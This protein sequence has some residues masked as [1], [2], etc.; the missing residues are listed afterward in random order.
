MLHLKPQDKWAKYRENGVDFFQSLTAWETL[1]AEYSDQ[2]GKAVSDNVRVSVLL[3]H[4][5]EPYR[6]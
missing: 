1:V 6:E 3:E 5:P 4:A 2:R